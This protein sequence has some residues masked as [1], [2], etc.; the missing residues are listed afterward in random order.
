MAGFADG[1]L[2]KI[3]ILSLIFLIYVL[4]SATIIYLL[5]QGVFYLLKKR[6]FGPRWIFILAVILGIVILLVVI[7]RYN[8]F[9]DGNIDF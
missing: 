2:D 9:I 8:Y 5:S 4:P 7:L 3:V 6:I 1:I